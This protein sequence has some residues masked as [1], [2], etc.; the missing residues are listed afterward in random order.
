MVKKIIIIQNRTMQSMS[1]AV[2]LVVNCKAHE[3]VMSWG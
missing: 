1:V 2:R 3:G